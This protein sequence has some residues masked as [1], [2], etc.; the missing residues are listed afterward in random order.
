MSSVPSD[1]NEDS[2]RRL[3]LNLNGYFGERIELDKVLG[4]CREVALRNGWAEEIIPVNAKYKLQAYHAAASSTPASR[5][6]YISAG[7]HGD[8][9]AGPLAALKLLSSLREF[10]QFEFWL[11]P[12]LNPTGFALGKRENADGIDLNREYLHPRTEETRTHITWLNQLPKFD[13]CFCLHED[14]E[15]H[16]FY[17]YEL[18]PERLPTIAPGI[19]E[20]VAKVCPVDTS[21][22]IEGRPA[23]GGMIRPLIDPRSRPDWPE[24]FYL[25][26]HKTRISYTLE[27]PSDFPLKARVAALVTGVTCGLRQIQAQ[28]AWGS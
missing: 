24:A 19:I 22:L 25:I 9:P 18:N 16:G 17:L 23:Q 13:L 26:T 6:V 21:E 1:P 7:I 10:G 27:A 5:R 28:Q 2:I 14:W 3:G 20:A 4:E 8:E 15:S 11:C 12:C